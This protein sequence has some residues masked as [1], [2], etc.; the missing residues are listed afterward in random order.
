MFSIDKISDHA[1]LVRLLASVDAPLRRMDDN[2]KNF[3]DNLQG[4]NF[5]KLVEF[6][7]TICSIQ[8]RRYRSMAFA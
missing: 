2:L 8:A 1:E 3:H 7:L 6:W 4:K 5:Y